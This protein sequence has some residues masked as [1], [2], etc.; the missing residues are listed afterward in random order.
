MSIQKNHFAYMLLLLCCFPFAAMAQQED[1][2]TARSNTTNFTTKGLEFRKGDAAYLLL[3]FRT[4]LRAVYLS[5]TDD[6]DQAAFEGMIRRLRLRLEGFVFSP[7]MEYKIQLGFASNDLDMESGSPQIIR[8]AIFY[9]H[10]RKNLSFGLGQTKLPGN[11]ERLNSSG[12]LQM[13]DRSLANSKFSIDRDFGIFIEKDAA[14]K[15][16]W[17]LFRGAISTGEGRGQM[18]T[19]DGLA[20]TMRI[21]YL[22]LGKFTDDGDYFEGDLVFEKTPRLSAGFTYSKN[23]RTTRSGGQTGNYMYSAYDPEQ[24]LAADIQ[25]I[26]ADVVF[27]YQGW[28]FLGEYYTRDINHFSENDF[29]T[30]PEDQKIFLRMPAGNAYNLQLSKM[31]SPRDELA[32]RYTSITPHAG[33]KS[34]Q[35]HYRTRAAGYS[36]YFNRHKFKV[37]AY[38]G[39]D[40]REGSSPLLTEP[41]K[42]RVSAMLQVE[43]GI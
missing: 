27:K 28:A 18:R 21:E 11:R 5:R 17:L 26:M 42:N 29:V 24:L 3:R 1:A 36:H 33:V 6:K 34:Y 9:Y 8:D 19:D 7:K 35:Y 10:P 22:P 41:F 14:I 40:T 32:V 12:E 16:Q 31:I 20:Y 39:L 43:I 13:P 15:E 25:T 38:V 2:D 37:Q 30:F 4:Q 23:F